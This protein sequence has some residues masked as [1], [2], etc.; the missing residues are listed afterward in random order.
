MS[1][2]TSSEVYRVPYRKNDVDD[3][4]YVRILSLNNSLT[5]LDISRCSLLSSK[6][7]TISFLRLIN[8]KYLDVSFTALND[9]SELAIS[10]S[11]MVALNLSSC[12]VMNY[13]PLTN[14]TSLKLLYLRD[15]SFK[16]GDLLSGLIM[17]RSLDLTR[18]NISNLEFLNNLDHL[19]EISIEGCKNLII[20][21]KSYAI[22]DFLGNIS[23]LS[24]IKVINV[25]ETIF[26]D[27]DPL[28]V[29]HKKSIILQ[30]R[31]KR[32][33]ALLYFEVS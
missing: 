13:S 33:I 15:T 2:L 7:I 10:C 24:K 12:P 29:F 6:V 5:F 1:R 32:Y 14:M 23:K 27:I 20:Y 22:Q 28:S 21:S 25:A 18:T 4:I 11:M 8:I 19:E 9:I 3:D 16:D 17:L 30:T 26:Q 31:P